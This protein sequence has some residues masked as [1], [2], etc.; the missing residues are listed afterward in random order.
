MAREIE[1]LNW[2]R[3]EMARRRLEA[4]WIP[5]I[6]EAVQRGAETAA[7]LARRDLTSL[8]QEAARV[9]GEGLKKEVWRLYEDVNDA[10]YRDFQLSEIDDGLAKA[11]DPIV[12]PLHVQKIYERIE[13]Q[14]AEK[15]KGID[16]ATAAQIRS[17]LTSHYTNGDLDVENIIRSLRDSYAFSRARGERIARTEI[18]YMGNAS[19]HY[20]I[21]MNARTEVITKSW[22]AVGDERT[23]PTHSTASGTQRDLPFSQPFEVGGSRLMFPGDSSLGAPGRETIQCRCTVLYGRKRREPP[24][25]PPP[26]PEPAPPKPAPSP[27]KPK[28]SPKPVRTPTPAPATG[29]PFQE[30]LWEKDPQAHYQAVKEHGKRIV[31]EMMKH[32][33]AYAER[34]DFLERYNELAD[35]IKK[36]TQ[37]RN[38]DR[39]KDLQRRMGLLLESNIKWSDRVR[40]AFE[41]VLSRTVPAGGKEHKFA[42]TFDPKMKKDGISRVESMLNFFSSV[43]RT[44]E[45]SPMKISFHL[46]PSGSRAYAKP[47]EN[48]V[49]VAPSSVQY[50]WDNVLAHEIGH[51]LEGNLEH[52]GVAIRHHYALRTRGE[53]ARRLSGGGYR[54]DEVTKVDQF[55]LEYA[56]KYYG[57]NSKYTEVFTTTIEA[58]FSSDR[59]HQIMTKDRETFEVVL[60]ALAYGRKFP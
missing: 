20:S 27:P 22:S 6:A 19:T 1:V 58:L 57:P 18:V 14:L 47:W 16:S 31:D 48:S 33:S 37:A 9:L 43:L 56:G 41:Q 39:A 50:I 3:M 30:R 12:N 2:K 23:R 7:R 45:K 59:F 42:P 51:L 13:R 46:L 21:E 34:E 55:A 36:A 28:P 11:A 54:P 49:F 35:E 38:M 32:L 26:K 40:S 25:P 24:P 52:I 60:G 29:D 17:V 15:I 44:D 4:R 53:T 8:P 10:F 5:R